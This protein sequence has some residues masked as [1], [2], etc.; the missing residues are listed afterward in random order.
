VSRTRGGLTGRVAREH[1][2]FTITR[3]GRADVMLISV[4]AHDRRT[5]LRAVM[6]CLRRFMKPPARTVAAHRWLRHSGPSLLIEPSSPI[7]N[8][9]AGRSRAPSLIDVA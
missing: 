3:N 6:G 5:S 2:H 7:R 9:T 1:D 4:A 8:S